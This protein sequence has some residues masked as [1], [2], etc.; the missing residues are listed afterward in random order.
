MKFRKNTEQTKWK[1]KKEK[2]ISGSN[3][4]TD[5]VV[6]KEKTV[7]WTVIQFDIH[8]H[9]LTG[10]AVSAQLKFSLFAVYTIQIAT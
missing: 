8:I 10:P 6:K 4:F 2:L 5:S 7:P 1:K 9:G 3:Y